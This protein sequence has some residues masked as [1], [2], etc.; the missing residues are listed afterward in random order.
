MSHLFKLKKDGQDNYIKFESGKLWYSGNNKD[1]FECNENFDV[2]FWLRYDSIH[3]FVCKDKNGKD[4]FADDLIGIIVN[5]ELRKLGTVVFLTFQWCVKR[6]VRD[7][8]KYYYDKLQLFMPD[9]E[10]IEEQE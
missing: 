4:V 7:T 10:L 1:W 8:D 6:R 3:P 9:I 5:G 2:T